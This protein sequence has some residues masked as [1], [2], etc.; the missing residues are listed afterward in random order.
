[1]KNM[2]LDEIEDIAISEHATQTN[3]A[4]CQSC[5][6]NLTF[7]PEKQILECEHCGS[8]KSFDMS[9]SEELDFSNL[10]KSAAP[11]SE[12]TRVY[13]CSNCG[14]KEILTSTDI[15][16]SCS[17]CGTSNIVVTEELAGLK[18]NAVVPFH[19][20]HE[21]AS[22]NAVAWAQ[23]RFFAS[24]KFKKSISTDTVN[25]LYNPAFTFDTNT[26]STYSGRL[27]IR[28]TRTVRVNGK[29]VTQSY[30]V[31]FNIG[32]TYSSFYDD[33][34]V[35]AS[36]QIPQASLDK[37]QPFETNKAMNY[38][39]EFLHGYTA[40]QYSKDGTACWD[41][42]RGMIDRNIRKSILAKYTYTTVESL[43]INTNY[44]NI[45]YKYLLLPI[46]V[47][48]FNFKQKLYNFFVSGFNGK[49]TGKV[50]LSPIKIGITV[51]LALAALFFL[52]KL[53]LNLMN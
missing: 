21:V 20:T 9:N 28:K 6:A 46:Y 15:A 32:G 17:F 45:K 43:T 25:G 8:T 31:Y 51:A 5:G 47:G 7:S 41:T 39:N 11:W 26:F 22:S 29:T 1:M 13:H 10:L 23:K 30:M 16:K 33:I 42:A 36:T 48:H 24:E 44:N 52:V 34:L 19:I 18:P 37:L 53:T 40:S 35:Q 3:T 50:P 2:S 12:E 49:V 14:S 38:T 4:K 27:G